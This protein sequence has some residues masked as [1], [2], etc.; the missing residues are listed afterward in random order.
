M[1]TG[2]TSDGWEATIL[3]E[4]KVL[5]TTSDYAV[6][7]YVLRDAKKSL[8]AAVTEWDKG[9]YSGKVALLDS[10]LIGSK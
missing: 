5:M 2:P 9:Y 7:R 4:V 6:M 10:I 8:V 1:E 3:I